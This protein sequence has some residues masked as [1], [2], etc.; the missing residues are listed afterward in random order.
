MPSTGTPQAEKEHKETTPSFRES[1]VRL[2]PG[3][4][5]RSPWIIL[6]LLTGIL[7]FVLLRWDE[8]ESGK[9]V[10]ETNNAYIH[11]DTVIMEAKVGG[12]VREV[13]FTDFQEVNAGDT[14]VTL[15]D[16]DYHM[17]VLQAEAKKEHAAA[18]LDNLDLE[19]EL[20]EAYVEQAKAVVTSAAAR[21]DLTTR[22]DK[23][24]S[25]LVRQRAVAIKEAETAEANL[26]TATAAHQESTALM[27]VQERKLALLQADRVLRK[28]DLKAAEASLET[29]R[30]DLGH[31]R[32]TAPSKSRTGSCKIR[33]GE[34]V[35]AGT[36]VVT[37]VPDAVPHVIANY[38]ETQLTSIR[39]GQPVAIRVDTFP[40]EE[41][42]GRVASI[43]PATGA[44]FSLLP[45]DN[46]SGNFTKVVQRIPV[47]I[48]FDSGQARVKDIRAGMSV[49]T[50]IDTENG[51]GSR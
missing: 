3:I 26:K 12:Y 11:F 40:G 41:L 29:A 8:Y 28:A 35:K 48:E 18:T 22:E 17:A 37:L 32:I 16:D 44:T 1:A 15:V 5:R 43:S 20:Q 25:R 42:T 47:R 49:V 4:Y 6:V 50:R 36:Q 46:T 51:H 19:I 13:A 34:L 38:K 24:L 14:L 2:L 7:V 10:Q 31:T 39:E 45:T 33:V 23:R 9:R 30:I 27:R 21:L